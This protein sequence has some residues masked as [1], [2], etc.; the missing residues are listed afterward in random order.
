[1]T[2]I[3]YSLN[4]RFRTGMTMLLFAMIMATVTVMAVVIDA[5]QN[6]VKLDDK[7]T[8]VSLTSRC[9]RRC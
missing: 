2:A 7:S 4:S 8:A 3:A 6:L 5:A 9:R 1:M